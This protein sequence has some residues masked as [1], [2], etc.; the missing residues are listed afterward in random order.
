ML[1]AGRVRED[2]DLGI[3]VLPERYEFLV[4]R[5]GSEISALPCTVIIARFSQ[6]A[7]RCRHLVPQLLCPDFHKVRLSAECPSVFNLVV[8]LIENAGEDIRH[9]VDLGHKGLE[10]AESGAGQW[11]LDC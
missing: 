11:G 8:D 7:E 4:E 5:L 9:S 1:D 3:D 2:F 6:T 10:G